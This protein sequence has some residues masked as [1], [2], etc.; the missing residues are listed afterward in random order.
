MS[1]AK[2]VYNPSA[3]A[4]K[5]YRESY[6]LDMFKLATERGKEGQS[7]GV[8]EINPLT[9]TFPSKME[10]CGPTFGKPGKDSL[11]TITFMSKF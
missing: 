5:R 2:L 7:K 4:E 11:H 3:T 6:S 1:G 9:G 10:Q 8:G